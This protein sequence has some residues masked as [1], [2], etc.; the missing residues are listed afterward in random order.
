MSDMA[1]WICEQTGNLETVAPA[2]SKMKELLIASGGGEQQPQY[3]IRYWL[4]DNAVLSENAKQSPWCSTREAGLPS[5]VAAMSEKEEQELVDSIL[6]GL[7]EHQNLVICL[8][9]ASSR[10]LATINK[11]VHI[12]VV[13]ASNLA[14]LA[15]ALEGTG[16]TIGRVTTT[17]WKPSK[18]SVEILAGHVKASVE[19]E[20]PSAIVFQMLDNLFYMGRK[21]DGTT[22][23]PAKDKKGQFHIEGDLVLDLE[24][25]GTVTICEHKL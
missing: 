19:G 9:S 17:N 4:T 1:M 6:F 22:K 25:L 3:P 21:I 13:G 20:R 23:Q 16:I 8:P 10:A 5:K 7:K 15:S 12:L 24:L 18:E 11:P 2:F 14:R